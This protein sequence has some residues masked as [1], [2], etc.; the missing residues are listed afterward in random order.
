MAN[1][2]RN[3]Q[4]FAAVLDTFTV[5]ICVVDANRTVRIM[6]RRARQLFAEGSDFTLDRGL[7]ACVDR[8]AKS[9]LTSAVA[10]VCK[11]G[12]LHES[13]RIGTNRPDRECQV[14]ISPL[15]TCTVVGPAADSL[16]LVVFG[17]SANDDYSEGNLR[18]LF[19]LSGAEAS[20]L[21]E[22]LSGK[23]LEECAEARGTT[24]GTARTQLKSIFVKTGTTSQG[25]LIAVAKAL[26]ATIAWRQL[27]SLDHLRMS[28]DRERARATLRRRY[29]DVHGPL[30]E[31]RKLT[32]RD[33]L[34]RLVDRRQMMKLIE[35]TG[36]AGMPFCLALIELDHFRRG[37]GAHGLAGG[38]E[39]VREF[40]Q[41]A[42]A[43]VRGQDVLGRWGGEEFVLMQP[44]AQLVHARQ[45]V[46]RMR[47]RIEELEIGQG[48]QPITVTISGGV[49]EHREGES[50]RQM[51]AR[52]GLALFRAKSSG[53]NRIV[54]D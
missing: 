43:A 32:A 51:L 7:L 47:S 9:R 34:T 14:S 15:L 53:C 28:I 42:L 1:P 23:R 29:G 41:A 24:I 21:K 49:V 13:F 4:V 5:A 8:E 17:R 35:A 40:A 52:A 16:A 18:A 19:E 33:K 25:Q 6:N 46:E 31:V 20:L 11:L 10:A 22:L 30:D 38:D 50:A 54:A 45:S 48:Q 39:V 36:A 3:D 12:S 2:A 44:E 37:N 26:P 27:E